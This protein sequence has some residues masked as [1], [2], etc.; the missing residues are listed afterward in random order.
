MLQRTREAIGERVNLVH[1]LDRGASGCLLFAKTASDDDGLGATST[2]HQ[3][4][5]EN[6]TKTYIALVRG[7]G[8]LKGRDFQEEGWF[9]VDRPI[10]DE[11][12]KLK[13]AV[14]N[15]R[16]IAGQDNEAG[17]IDRPRASLVLAR[18]E[19]GRWHQIRRHLNGLSPPI[20]GDTSH[21]DNRVNREWRD[22][23]DMLPERTCL[24]LVSLEIPPNPIS[25]D[26]ISVTSPLASDMM[27]V[28]E[29]YLPNLLEASKGA[30][31]EEGISFES[32]DERM[33]TVRIQLEI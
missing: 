8:I 27:S 11:N 13:D 2:L 1:R 9:T 15:F 6:A 22:R 25:P 14:T 31:L 20:L 4:M 28:L 32:Q 19:T 3:A 7:E 26:G 16:F 21:G 5:A 24:H 10:K 23:R 17:A 12:G 29:N 30:L 33:S 18:P